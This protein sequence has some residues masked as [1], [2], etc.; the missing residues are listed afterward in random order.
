[1]ATSPLRPTTSI[2]FQLNT[3]GYSLS[4][5]RMGLSF[6]IAAGPRQRSHCLVRIPRDSRLLLSQIRDF[7]NL[8]GQVPVFI[9][10]R[11][12]VAQLYLQAVGSILVASYD[13]QGYVQFQNERFCGVCRFVRCLQSSQEFSVLH[14]VQTGSRVHPTPFPMGTVGSFR[15][16]NRSGREADQSPPVSTEVKKYGSIHPLPHTPSWVSA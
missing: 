11:N 3:C 5:G 9:S 10:S 2:F 1:L 14:V 7:P 4:D 6:T 8:E 16:V 15:G 13:S 12:R